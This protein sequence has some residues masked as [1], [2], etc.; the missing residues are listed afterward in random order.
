MRPDQT[1]NMPVG[2]TVRQTVELTG[3]LRAIAN[4][5]QALSLRDH[6]DSPRDEEDSIH[7]NSAAELLETLAAAAHDAICMHR[8]P[9]IVSTCDGEEYIAIFI[10]RPFPF[11]RLRVV[12]DPL[13]AI[14]PD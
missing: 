2:I 6:K 4:R 11:P 10:E 5:L 14:G 12:R 7:L 8:P 9:E 3:R 13:T 1:N